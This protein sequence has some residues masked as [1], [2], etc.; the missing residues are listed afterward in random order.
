MY[1][2]ITSSSDGGGF[3]CRG[4]HEVMILDDA[5]LQQELRDGS[6]NRTVVIGA[7]LEPE[8]RR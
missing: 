7:E 6:F 8:S 5:A 4:R 3:E 1:S 2:R